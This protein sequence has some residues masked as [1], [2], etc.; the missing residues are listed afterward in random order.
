[1]R[2]YGI[3]PLWL[4]SFIIPSHNEVAS[5]YRICPVPKH[6]DFH[7][8][9]HGGHLGYQNGTILAILNLHVA[10]CCYKFGSI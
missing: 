7:D 10:P 8:G 3:S 9:C 4:L 1:M 2:A 6:E 5:G